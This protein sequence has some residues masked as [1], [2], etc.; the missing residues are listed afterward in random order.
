MIHGKHLESPGR[1]Q[2]R[3]EEL[4]SPVSILDKKTWEGGCHCWATSVAHV[5]GEDGVVNRPAM[6]RGLVCSLLLSR[7][8]SVLQKNASERTCFQFNSQ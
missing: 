8:L 1:W 7:S 2:K 5:A 6:V 3:R 4:P